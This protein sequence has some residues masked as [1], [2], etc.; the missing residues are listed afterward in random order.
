MRNDT[1][2]KGITEVEKTAYHEAGHAVIGI[3]LGL[4]IGLVSLKPTAVYVGMTHAK[5]LS[6]EK[7]TL[8]Q[9]VTALAGPCAQGRR[10]RNY[11]L[12]FLD[13]GSRDWGYVQECGK[14][15]R[16]TPQ[17]MADMERGTRRFVGRAWPVVDAF[18]K[19]L[20][21]LTN[22]SAEEATAIVKKAKG[23]SV[24]S[25]DMHRWVAKQE[26]RLPIPSGLAGSLLGDR[27]RTMT[28]SEVCEFRQKLETLDE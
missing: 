10:V 5:A 19:R 15:L 24:L 20:L 12:A 23:S 1:A 17:I 7:F 9:M 27:Y 4:D 22:V 18:A 21:A 26:G 11:C 16:C 3:M 25:S 13:G 8:R 14:Y 2:R 28:D 6:I